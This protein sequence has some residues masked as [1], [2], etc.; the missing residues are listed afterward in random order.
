MVG[1]DVDDDIECEGCKFVFD[2][3]HRDYQIPYSPVQYVKLSFARAESLL[4]RR[5]SPLLQAAYIVS[6]GIWM[7]CNQPGVMSDILKMAAL[8][9]LLNSDS[10]NGE[11]TEVNL[12]RQVTM[13]LEWLHKFSVRAQQR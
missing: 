11:L 9:S 4:M 2:Q 8:W 10:T 13:L 3:P 12:Q 6:K 1:R 7:H 5:S